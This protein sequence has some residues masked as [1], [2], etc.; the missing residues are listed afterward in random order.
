MG[1]TA[2]VV[3]LALACPP[4]DGLASHQDGRDG[5]AASHRVPA[6]QSFENIACPTRHHCVAVGSSQTFTGIVTLLTNARVSGAPVKVPGT[7]DLYGIACMTRSRCV[8]VGQGASNG[9]LV[10]IVNGHVLAAGTVPGTYGLYA[11]SCGSKNSCWATGTGT[12][13][14]HSVIVDIHAGQSD[15]P[16]SV[17][18]VSS[19][20]FDDASSGLAC[21]SATSCLAV[22]STKSNGKGFIVWIKDG[23]PGKVRTVRGTTVLS[24]V[25]CGTT[26][27]CTAVG[28]S[29]FAESSH[30]IVVSIRHR[31]HVHVERAPRVTF[32]FSVRCAP[33]QGCL[34]T[35]QIGG[36]GATQALNGTKIGT[37]HEIRVSKSLP[38]AASTGSGHYLAVG[39]R[40]SASAAS[41]F[42][43]LVETVS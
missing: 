14:K 27:N 16:V 1:L 6:A 34:A 30:G 21:S 25:V 32:L 24:G 39:V 17:K 42:V 36:H 10:P 5:L 20:A 29:S 15:K 35:G 43:G 23:N 7:S 3:G 40:K 18:G 28:S 2:L 11:V 9:V 37:T 26:D 38:A 19:Y 33:G 13:F 12:G 22:G 4:A 31:Q 8:A 41:G